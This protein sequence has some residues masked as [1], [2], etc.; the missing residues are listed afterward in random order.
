MLFAPGP[1]EMEEKIR[2]IASMKLPYFRG[3]GY[4]N[5]ML[6]LTEGL[7]YI[8]QTESTPLTVTSSGTGV[9]EMALQNLF[10]PG[11]RVVV[12]NGGTFGQRW[13]EMCGVYGI[14]VHEISIDPG[15]LPDLDKIEEMLTNDIKALLVNAHETSTGLLYDIKEIGKLTSSKDFM[16][17]VD[18]VSTIGADEFNMDEW[19]C[20]CVLLSS[21]KALAC[22]PGLSF[23]AFSNRARKAMKNVKQRGY[24]FDAEKHINNISRGMT[25]FTPA[26]AVTFQLK[27]RIEMIKKCGLNEYIEQHAVKAAVFR[28]T[29]LA[30]DEFSVLP[31]RQSNALTAVMLPEYC[32]ARS[33]IAYLDENYGWSFAPNP[34]NDRYFRVSHMG[35]TSKENMIEVAEKIKEASLFMKD[36]KG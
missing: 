19:M 23:I 8:F 10:N 13:V 24:Y 30:N 7:K 29:L 9:M 2:E 25:P 18:A 20:D 31:E 12:L 26:M 16:L 33:L 15:K 32:G 6:E 14:N 35:N 5:M 4:A 11:D 34:N 17:I 1:T 21:Q 27:E 22:L 3:A 28:D 36:K